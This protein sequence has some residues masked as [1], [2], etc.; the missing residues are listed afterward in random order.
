MVQCIIVYKGQPI[1]IQRTVIY[2]LTPPI[3]LLQCES[4]KSPCS[5]LT[6][7]LK[8]LGIFNQFFIHL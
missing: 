7:Y 5:F 4:N 2:T 6:F 3:I 8:R 1:I